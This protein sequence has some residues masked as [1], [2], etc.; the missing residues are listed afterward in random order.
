M[1]CQ[2]SCLT[3][4]TFPSPCCCELLSLAAAWQG[5]VLRRRRR[6]HGPRRQGLRSMCNCRETLIFVE[7]QLSWDKMSFSWEVPLLQKLVQLLKLFP[8][9]YVKSYGFHLAAVNEEGRGESLLH[10]FQLALKH[11]LT[12]EKAPSRIRNATVMSK[13]TSWLAF[14]QSLKFEHSVG[15]P[16]SNTSVAVV[17]LWLMDPTAINEI[18]GALLSP[19]KCCDSRLTVERS[20][21]SLQESL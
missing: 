6:L 17:V 15:A 21:C 4:W 3:L 14:A 10:H 13:P 20:S 2:L 7:Q 11:T 9:Y 19:P 5:A 18:A 12:Q 16:A 1:P 8:G